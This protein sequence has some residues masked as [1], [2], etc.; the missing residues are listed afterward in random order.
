MKKVYIIIPI[1]LFAIIFSCKREP[2]IPTV[3]ICYDTQIEPILNNSCAT[4]GCH[5]AESNQGGY[6]FTNYENAMK[7]VIAGN[8]KESV[9]F[10]AI[11]KQS[12]SHKGISY[13]DI[14]SIKIWIKNGASGK[15]CLPPAPVIEVCDTNKFTFSE[16]IKPILKENCYPCHSE[17]NHNTSGSNL[18]FE[19]FATLKDFADT[20]YNSNIYAVVAHLPFANQMPKNGQKLDPCKI[21]QIKKWV[22]AGAPNN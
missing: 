11:E 4:S 13:S 16:T 3:D 5:N 9:I 19:D 20:T 1:I 2:Q 12:G 17:A 21:L 18:N 10:K 14:N 15:I 22:Y 7:G 6:A 8:Y